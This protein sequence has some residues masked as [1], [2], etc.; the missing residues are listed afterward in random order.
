MTQKRKATPRQLAALRLG[1]MAIANNPGKRRRISQ[2]GGLAQAKKIGSEGMAALAQSSDHRP[3]G[4]ARLAQMGSKGYSRMRALASSDSPAQIKHIEALG[5]Q[6][7][8]SGFL[9]SIRSVES[10][11]RGGV[12]CTHLR[13]HIARH[14]WNPDKCELC[15]EE[16]EKRKPAAT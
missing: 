12:A 9:E 7:V 8:A 2:A 11:R 6:N 10:S 5:N 16:L 1:P 15:Y 3:G 13:W 14:R 4:V